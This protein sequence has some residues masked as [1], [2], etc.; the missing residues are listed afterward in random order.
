MTTT[1]L[2]WCLSC[3][4]SGYD[5]SGECPMCRVSGA[6][7]YLVLAPAANEVAVARIPA[8]TGAE[9]PGGCLKP[10]TVLQYAAVPGDALGWGA[11]VCTWGAAKGVSHHRH[12]R[13]RAVWQRAARMIGSGDQAEAS[14][15]YVVCEQR[16]WYGKQVWVAVDI[17][18]E[19]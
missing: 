7:P 8:R 18:T 17:R 14:V 16:D 12:Q 19:G 15:L 9:W 10:D 6:M 5:S 13:D 11:S 1:T 2:N 3:D 4:G